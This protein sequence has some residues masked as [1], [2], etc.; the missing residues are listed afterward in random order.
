MDAITFNP[1]LP[2]KI[3]P[4]PDLDTV[5]GSPNLT[6][7]AV[8]WEQEARGVA[9]MLHAVFANATALSQARALSVAVTELENVKAKCMEAETTGDFHLVGRLQVVEC[10]LKGLIEAQR[11][12]DYIMKLAEGYTMKLELSLGITVEGA[13]YERMRSSRVTEMFVLIPRVC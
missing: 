5:I 12:L 6:A 4:E 7:G 2:T 9:S 10:W 8:A 11:V 1:T 3:D 13:A